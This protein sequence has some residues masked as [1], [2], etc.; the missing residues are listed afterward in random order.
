MWYLYLSHRELIQEAFVI[1][2]RIVRKLY[3]SH[4]ELIRHNDTDNR[5]YNY[6]YLSHRELILKTCNIMTFIASLYLSHRE[7][8][9][10]VGAV[11]DAV[12]VFT[13]PVG[14]EM[15]ALLQKQL[16]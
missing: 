15:S 12:V 7:L 3:L 16:L 6:L 9:H 4:R 5:T 1:H 13:F 8:I 2:V 11:V 10:S 14:N